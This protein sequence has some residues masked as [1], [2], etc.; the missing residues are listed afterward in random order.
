MEASYHDKATGTKKTVVAGGGNGDGKPKRLK[1]TYASEVSARQ[2]AESEHKR[3]SRSKATAS[4][5]LALGRP[6]ITPE[7]P[8]TLTGFKTEIDCHKWLVKEAEHR[9][10]GNGGLSSRLK[11][12]TA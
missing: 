11:L 2:A 1:N 7:R 9:M 8:I 5:S 4:I 6:N 10:D 3:V 12:E